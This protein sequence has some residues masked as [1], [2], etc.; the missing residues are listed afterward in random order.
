MKD[1]QSYISIFV[2]YLTFQVAA[3]SISPDMA[4]VFYETPF[5]RFMKVQRNL[6]RKKL[7]G[8]N[9]GSSFLGGSF[10][11]YRVVLSVLIAISGDILG[12]LKRYCTPE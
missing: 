2:A 10:T 3:R 7:H 8:K 6:G 1:Q 5:G 11:K 12:K 9:Q 4:A